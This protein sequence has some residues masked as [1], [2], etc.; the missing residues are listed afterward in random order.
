MN[1][2]NEIHHLVDQLDEGALDGAAAAL[3]IR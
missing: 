1:I 2:K 3:E